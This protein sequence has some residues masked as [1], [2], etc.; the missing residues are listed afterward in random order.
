M[1]LKQ[2]LLIAFVLGV[3]SLTAWECYWR[4]QGKTPT[5][6]DDNALWAST[7]SRVE[8]L[9]KDD[10]VFVGSSRIHFDVQLEI[11]ENLTGK[12]PVQLAMGGASPLPVFRD[13]V[14]NTDYNG[15]IVV[16]ITPPLFFSTTFPQAPPI[17]GPQEKVDHYQNRTYAQ[18]FN[19]WLSL[20]LQRNIAFVQSYEDMLAGNFDLK[21]LIETIKM[22]N[23][24]EK[25][26]MPP[27]YDFGVIS[28]D[29]NVRMADKFEKDS[30]WAQTV[31]DVWMFCLQGNAD[32]PPPD[33]EGTS[34][35]FLEDLQIFQER[36]G[37]VILLRCPS[38][39]KFREIENK[40]TPREAFWDELVKK[41]GLPAYHFEDYKQ[42]QGLRI[43]EWS[44]LAAEDADHFTKELIKLMQKDGAINL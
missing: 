4:S 31:I 13:V 11:W 35:F 30:T 39:N 15:T 9:T 28:E 17:S 19:Q 24:T 14:R 34:S 1:N 36:G 21:S 41:S 38:A 20:P 25:P 5:F 22:G 16:G 43:P 7:R 6:Q 8:K 32:M 10:F 42:L 44:H 12:K 26:I 33:K 2:S 23:R 29:R 3:I 40:I 27:F 18:R 37:K